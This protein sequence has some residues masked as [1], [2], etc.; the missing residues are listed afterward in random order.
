[1]ISI[2]GNKAILVGGNVNSSTKGQQKVGTKEY[3]LDA[4]NKILPNGVN[5]SDPIRQVYAHGSILRSKNIK[6]ITKGLRDKNL[7]LTIAEVA[8]LELDN[9]PVGKVEIDPE[10]E[11][12]VRKYIQGGEYSGI[13]F[14]PNGTLA[15]IPRDAPHLGIS[16]V[17]IDEEKYGPIPPKFKSSEGI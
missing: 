13:Y 1:M 9:W 12:I 2:S 8:K 10:C 16:S 5:S 15:K 7:N 14:N 3:L 6:K 4:D 11:D 17:Y